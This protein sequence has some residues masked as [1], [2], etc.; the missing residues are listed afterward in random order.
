GAPAG[1]GEKHPVV[2]ARERQRRS[3]LVAH[4]VLFLAERHHAAN[5]ATK[6][7]EK[8]LTGVR[9]GGAVEERGDVL[10]SGQ[11]LDSA[12]SSVAAPVDQRALWKRTRPECQRRGD[13]GAGHQ[14]LLER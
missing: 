4:E 11:P 6:P 2:E 9:A 7:F 10:E 13:G 14:R 3:E 5:G 8:R 1:N 12:V